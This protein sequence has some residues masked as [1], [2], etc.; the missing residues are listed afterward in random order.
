MQDLIKKKSWVDKLYYLVGKQNFDFRLNCIFKKDGEVIS[1]KY[2]KYSECIFPIDFDGSCEDKK[3]EW[4]FKGL[5]N[6]EIF[7]NEVQLDLEEADKLKDVLKKLKKDKIKNFTIWTTHSRGNHISIFFNKNLDSEE[8]LF[9]I[10][11]Y[12]GDTQKA[13]N[14]MIALEHSPHWKSGKE[15]EEINGI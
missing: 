8:K 15:K 11:R 3:I 6:R 12:G 5:N 10:K 14:T 13:G 9:I 2:Q 1:S 7:P 4:F